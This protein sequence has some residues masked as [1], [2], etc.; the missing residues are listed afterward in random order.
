MADTEENYKGK[1]AWLKAARKSCIGV[2]A[3][4][5]N[6]YGF[7][8]FYRD[9]CECLLGVDDSVGAVLDT[10]EKEG[11][12]EDTLVIFMSDNGFLCGEHGLIDKRNMYEPSIRVPLIV[13]CPALADR[14]RFREE[15]VLNMDLAPTILE[16]AGA[17]PLPS[18]HGRSFL[19]LVKG[20]P[21]GWRTEF[22]YE[23]FWERDY[24]QNPSV[25][26][27]RTD[28]YSYMRYHGIWDINELYDIENDP[29]QMNNLLGDVRITTQ[30]GY[31]IESSSVM[32]R[33]S[34]NMYNGQ[35]KDPELRS[36][37]FDLERRLFEILD[38]TG[39]RV[40]PSW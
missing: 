11:L 2:D 33:R 36:L 27:L 32:D 6:R 28:K 39:G 37:V 7:D 10:L 4:Y 22:L 40:E 25:L 3:M 14:G 18:I 19:P 24:P 12:I 1:P 13:H 26:G 15:L 30:V 5:D 23:Y 16:A 38:Q 8:R 17:S 20:E 31:E 29:H 21:A 9:Y 34:R 35:I